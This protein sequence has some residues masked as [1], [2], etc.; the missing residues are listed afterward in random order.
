[1][2]DHT[3]ELDQHPSEKKINPSVQQEVGRSAIDQGMRDVLNQLS[4]ERDVKDV[5]EDIHQEAENSKIS[6]GTEV[7]SSISANDDEGIKDKSR[8]SFIGKGIL[9]LTTLFGFGATA[10]TINDLRN[11][12]EKQVQDQLNAIK[13]N[14]NPDSV[15]NVN[16]IYAPGN[17]QNASVQAENSSTQDQTETQEQNPE[18][19]GNR[20]D[21]VIKT[22]TSGYSPDEKNEIKKLIGEKEKNETQDPSAFETKKA[23]TLQWVDTIH[24]V[25][26]EFKNEGVEI[27]EKLVELLPAFIYVESGGEVSADSVTGAAGVCQFEPATAKEVDKEISLKMIPDSIH[28]MTDQAAREYLNTHPKESIMLALRYLQDLYNQFSHDIDGRMLAMEA[29]NM[30]IGNI[31][32][33][34]EAFKEAGDGKTTPNFI[35]MIDSPAFKAKEALFDTDPEQG[36]RPETREYAVKILAATD[37]LKLPI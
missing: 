27:D 9:A 25:A 1:M 30:G 28:D 22:F 24:Q 8:R 33:M 36:F 7:S 31:H 14:P 26:Q 18:Q 10:K 21:N 11:K 3:K 20:L 32:Q 5:R 35:Q 16:V 12:Q 6:K 15:Q 23:N 19:D 17:P 37:L 4:P 34:I 13:G 29:Y 2:D